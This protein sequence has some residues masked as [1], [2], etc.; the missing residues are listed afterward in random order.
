MRFLYQNDDEEQ[1]LLFQKALKLTKKVTY[2]EFSTSYLVKYQ[3]DATMEID[4]TEEVPTS[5]RLEDG[6]IVRI[7]WGDNPIFHKACEVCVAWDVLE[8]M[9][10]E[11]YENKEQILSNLIKASGEA[12]ELLGIFRQEKTI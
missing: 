11:D 5:Y 10:Y 12:P 1:M 3:E 9:L 7:P 6:E 4:V 2:I 8:P